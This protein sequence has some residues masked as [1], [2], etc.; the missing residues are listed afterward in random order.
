MLSLSA[1][2]Q[3]MVRLLWAPQCGR[4]RTLEL[5]VIFWKASKPQELQMGRVFVVAFHIIVN[6]P[7][8]LMTAS[9]KNIPLNPCVLSKLR[10][11]FLLLTKASVSF[12]FLPV[13]FD[14]WAK[15]GETLSRNV[16]VEAGGHRMQWVECPP[17]T[18]RGFWSHT[19]GSFSTCQPTKRL[20]RHYDNIY[21][22]LKKFYQEPSC[23]A[24]DR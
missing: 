10:P 6:N 20:P 2:H 16:F 7:K 18:W 19:R 21:D 8:N 9:H 22:F 23:Q 12:H 5:F 14:F 1:W 4:M 11:G 24:R 3:L 17:S 13:L 15:N